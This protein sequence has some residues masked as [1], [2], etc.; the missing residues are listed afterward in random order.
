MQRTP[1]TQ[2]C[3]ALA[4]QWE[5]HSTMNYYKFLSKSVGRGLPLITRQSG[6]I[7]TTV[8]R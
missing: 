7:Y 2:N 6:R 8:A 5:L 1:D 3:A 4:E